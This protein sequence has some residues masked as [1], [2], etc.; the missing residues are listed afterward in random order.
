M[1]D[2]SRRSR[3]HMVLAV[4]AGLGA[5]A[6]C[7][8]PAMAQQ[9]SAGDIQWAQTI[10]KEKNYNIGGRAN[11]QMTPETR[12]ALSQY[13]KANGLPVTG[14][15]DAA[16]VNKMMA[17]RGAK[18]SN[19][20]GNL[21][22]Q[23]VGGGGPGQEPRQTREVVPRAAQRTGDVD[24]VGGGEATLGP[25]VRGA[26]GE[27]PAA[28]SSLSPG[29]APQAAP[30]GSVTATTADGKVVPATALSKDEDGF[31]VPGWLR[32]VVM[33]VLAGTVGYLGIGWWRSGRA[34]GSAPARDED[35]REM[36]REPTFTPRREELTTGPLP[37]LSSG[38]RR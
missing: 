1:A 19:T 9:P 3:P 35:P 34:T 22:Q 21:A 2:G 16:T 28:A 14:N 7:A 29:S 36:R 17:E 37:R 20:M 33:A 11:G 24:N 15:L 5:G 23:K 10:L 30:R 32:Y 27:M 25:V 13:Q 38:R 8:V 4:L 12:S 26:P 6:L 18:P 31:K